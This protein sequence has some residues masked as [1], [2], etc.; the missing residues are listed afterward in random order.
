MNPK[1][2]YWMYE[3][4]TKEYTFRFKEGRLTVEAESEAEAKILAQAEAIKRGWDYEI[5]P[6]TMEMDE[7]MELID[8][9]V[10]EV[11]NAYKERIN[12]YED[13]DTFEK[14]NLNMIEGALATLIVEAYNN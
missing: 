10:Y 3:T 1:L 7:L 4:K 11:L 5:L 2:L 6:N 14:V 9:K 13:L 12:E 8:D